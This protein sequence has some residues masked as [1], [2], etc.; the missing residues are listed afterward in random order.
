MYKL[1]GGK[2]EVHS[3]KKTAVPKLI[4]KIIKQPVSLCHKNVLIYG[5][6]GHVPRAADFLRFPQ[7]IP[8]VQTYKS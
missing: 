3:N 6:L 5:H 2:L 8:V 4:D 1:F 7:M